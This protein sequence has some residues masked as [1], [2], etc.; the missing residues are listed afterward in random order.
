MEV[1]QL[2]HVMNKLELKGSFSRRKLWESR[3]AN[4]YHVT[5]PSLVCPTSCNQSGTI[6]H[7]LHTI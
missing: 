2:E 1:D 6:M 4:P 5:K 7:A 3:D